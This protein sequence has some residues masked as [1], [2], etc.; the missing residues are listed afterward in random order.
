M[1]LSVGYTQSLYCAQVRFASAVGTARCADAHDTPSL[2][3]PLLP[4]V[5]PCLQVPN[6]AHVAS[7]AKRYGLKS[8]SKAAASPGVGSKPSQLANVTTAAGESTSTIDSPSTPHTHGHAHVG[9]EGA[10]QSLIG[11]HSFLNASANLQNALFGADGPDTPSINAINK[12]I[13]PEGSK[14]DA[15]RMNQVRAGC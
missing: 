15:S 13:S 5:P 10:N 1:R 14:L 7:L 8:A 12:I 4:R 2:C 6:A 11:G 3:S 9:G